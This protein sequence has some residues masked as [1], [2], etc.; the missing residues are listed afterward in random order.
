MFIGKNYFIALIVFKNTFVSANLEGFF[1]VEVDEMS[2]DFMNVGGG[3]CRNGIDGGRYYDQVIVTKEFVNRGLA[4]QE[5]AD[6]FGQVDKI[7]GCAKLCDLEGELKCRGFDWRKDR[8]NFPLTDCYFYEEYPTYTATSTSRNNYEDWLCFSR[9]RTFSPTI[10]SEPTKAPVTTEPTKSQ[11]PTRNPTAAP[12]ASPTTRFKPTPAPITSSPT[13][14]SKPTPTPLEGF[15]PIEVDETS[16][17]FMNVGGGKCRNLIDGGRYYDQVIVTKEF[18]NRGLATQ[19]EVDNFG[20]VEKIRG[21]AKLCE[22]EGNKCKGFDWRKDRVK[23]SPL[24]DCYFYVVEPTYTATS[25]P[26][27][28]Y[29]D[30]LCFAREKTQ[31]QLLCDMLSYTREVC[32]NDTDECEAKANLGANGKESCDSW[33]GRSSLVCDKAWNDKNGCDKKREISCSKTGK[34]FSICRCKIG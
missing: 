25:T 13:V 3:K 30:W 29:E 14:S 12:T 27:N 16:T 32:M 20:Q 28:N 34:S 24:T 9:D 2:T 17:D 19:A 5:E 4:T 31:Y 8:V 33:C 10:S 23:S 7:K 26:R 22:L 15:F 11:E 21:C 6:N 1:P 18:V